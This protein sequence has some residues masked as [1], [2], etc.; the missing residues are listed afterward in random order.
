M[1]R[2]IALLAAFAL[3]VSGGCAAIQKS[4]AMDKERSLAAA[5]FQMKLAT[6]PEQI[7]KAEA[8]PQHKLTP[9]PGPNGENRFVYADATDCKCV[10]VGTDAAY[11]RYRNLQVKQRIAENEE[12]ASMNWGGWGAWGPWY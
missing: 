3:L 1:S 2:T 7:A 12:A 11:D 4:E 6:T 10:Y 5:G 8:L 9:T